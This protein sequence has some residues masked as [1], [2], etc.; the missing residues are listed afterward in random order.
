MR[1]RPAST[2]RPGTEASR[3]ANSGALAALACVTQ[4]SRSVKSRPNLAL[5]PPCPLSRPCRHVR[6]RREERMGVTKSRRTAM[7]A[8]AAGVVCEEPS[9]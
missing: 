8:C 1:P 7:W 3:S 2:S 9:E 6:G 4:A 5:P